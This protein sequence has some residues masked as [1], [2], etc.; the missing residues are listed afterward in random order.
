M[1]CT[2]GSSAREGSGLDECVSKGEIESTYTYLMA[3]QMIEDELRYA[4]HG[5]GNYPSEHAKATIASSWGRWPQRD[6]EAQFPKAL[7]SVQRH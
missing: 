5:D 4:E 1:A 6:S 3:D 2:D 7:S